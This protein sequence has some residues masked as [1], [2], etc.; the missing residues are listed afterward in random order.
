METTKIG[1]KAAT[2]TTVEEVKRTCK[3]HHSALTRGYM[4][5]KS[6]AEIHPY[7]GRYG[8]G[9]TVETPNYKT[10]NYHN[11]EYYIYK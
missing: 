3:Y 6:A 1:H 11:I 8:Q 7:A 4:S 10:N 9:Y 2:P 5:R